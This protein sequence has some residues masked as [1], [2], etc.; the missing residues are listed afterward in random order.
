MWLSTPVVTVLPNIAQ[1]V[2]ACSGQQPTLTA[3]AQV[4]RGWEAVALEQSMRA[5]VEKRKKIQA[6][7]EQALPPGEQATDE[8]LGPG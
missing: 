1:C 4:E 2:Q 6:E 7:L 3:A 8:V 5:V